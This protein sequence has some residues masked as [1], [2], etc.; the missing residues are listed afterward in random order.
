MNVNEQRL[1]FL[2]NSIHFI[3]DEEIRK[4]IINERNELLKVLDTK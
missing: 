4:E 3:N 2:T 1:E